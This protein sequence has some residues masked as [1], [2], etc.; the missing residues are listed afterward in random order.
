M[1]E[2]QLERTMSSDIQYHYSNLIRLRFGHFMLIRDVNG[3]HCIIRFR[4]NVSHTVKN[5]LSCTQNIYEC[6]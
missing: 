1:R 6:K 4:I 3:M 5:G 2:M